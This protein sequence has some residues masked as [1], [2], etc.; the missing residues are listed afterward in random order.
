[1]IRRSHILGLA[2]LAMVIGASAD[3]QAQFFGRGGGTGGLGSQMLRLGREETVLKEIEA[4]DEQKEKL[5]KMGEEAM[6][7]L[8]SGRGR[9]GRGGQRGRGGQG[10]ERRNLSQAEIQKMIADAAKKAKETSKK[11]RRELGDVLLPHQFERLQEISIQAMGVGAVN[12]DYVASKLKITDAQKK[13]F[14]AADKKRN[15]ARQKLF[16]SFR[17]GGRGNRGGGRG[18]FDFSKIQ[19]TMQE[20]Q[21]THEKDMMAVLTTDQKK[22]LEKMKGKAFKLPERRFGGRSRGR[23]GRG[24]RGGTTRQR[25]DL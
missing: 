19:A 23:G 12:D 17:G 22:E 7:S 6:R 1:M 18:N 20:M 8:F 24:G 2:A 3:A 5:A 10:G 16:S 4:L 14:A 15:D 11:A 13:K 9:G 21:K 25:D